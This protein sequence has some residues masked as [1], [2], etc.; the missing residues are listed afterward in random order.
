MA[1]PI[2]SN[3]NVNNYVD[4]SYLGFASSPSLA[5]VYPFVLRGI[6]A[7]KNVVKMYLMSQKGDYGRNVAKGGPLVAIIGKPINDDTQAKIQ[8]LIQDAIAQFSNIILAKTVIKPDKA[9]RGWV[10]SLAITDIYNKFST[11]LNLNIQTTG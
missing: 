9:N 4:F 3:A 10:V 7:I 1:V 6:D 5:Q 8:L 11:N 2:T